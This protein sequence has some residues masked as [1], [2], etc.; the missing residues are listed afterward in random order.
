LVFSLTL[1]S[2]G[3]KYGVDLNIRDFR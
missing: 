2:S 3:P 1:N